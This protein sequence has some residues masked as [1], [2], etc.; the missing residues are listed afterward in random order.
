M[1]WVQQERL[2]FF[3]YSKRHKDGC[4][5]ILFFAQDTPEDGDQKSGKAEPSSCFSET[6]RPF[7]VFVRRGNR[8]QM[9][10]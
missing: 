5:A 10:G 8:L 6:L 2:K 4:E 1:F 9:K 3:S 7:P